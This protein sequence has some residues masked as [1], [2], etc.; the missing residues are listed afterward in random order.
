MKNPF[1]DD[2]PPH[3]NPPWGPVPRGELLAAG[4][5]TIWVE[6]PGYEPFTKKLDL[7]AGDQVEVLA[8][9]ERVSYG[10]LLVDG[11]APKI[12]VTVDGQPRGVF[13]AGGQPLKLKEKAGKHRVVA[14]ADGKKT[15]DD[16]IEVPL[17]QS[18]EVHVV[19]VNKYGRGAAWAAA[20]AGA[21][22]L[23]GGAFFGVQ[24][25]KARDDMQA[26]RRAGRLAPDDTRGDKG[27]AF[28]YVADGC[29]VVG[30]ALAVLATYEFIRDPLPPSGA[31][32]D[33]PRDFEAPAPRKKKASLFEPRIRDLGF[34]PSPAGGGGFFVTGAF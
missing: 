16:E 10:Y 19:F 23:G 5:H 13:E 3:E 33:D 30:G 29:F 20:I 25:N 31:N 14:E 26:D 1:L 12:T 18:R 15:F 24:S 11:N 34:A 22:F 32:L 6:A 9:L 27:K 2:P 17:G 7:T 21:A 8:E 28:A 4:E